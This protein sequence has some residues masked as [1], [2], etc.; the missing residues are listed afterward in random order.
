MIIQWIVIAIFVFVGLLYIRLEH[1][2]S[3]IK[4]LIII[5]VGFIFY[6]TIVNHFT[7]DQVDLTSPR[8]I[9]NGVY[10]YVGWVGSTASNLWNVGTDTVHSVGNAV[11]IN[12]TEEDTEKN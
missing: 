9:V 1:G 11:K 2:M 6:F 12:N 4:I 8:G 10:L 5:I 3:K 7:S